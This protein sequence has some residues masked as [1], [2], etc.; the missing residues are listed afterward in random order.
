MSTADVCAAILWAGV[1]LYAIFG[2]A[3]FGAGVWDLLADLHITGRAGARPRISAERVRGQIDRS[4]GPVWE[5]NHVW[6]IFV[7][8]V[9]WTAFPTAF[10]AVMTT[11]YI[12]L[13]LAALGIVLRGSGFA[14]RHALPG[15]VQRRATTVFGISSVLTPFFMGTV[16]GAI[17]SGEVPAAGDGD[18]TGSWIGFL[19][20]VT[21]VLFVLV[22]AYTAAIFLVR[23]SGAAG[24]QDL[25]D[26]FA[27]R[28]LVAAVIAGAAAVVGVIALH[29]DA[30]Y[31]YDGLTSWPGIALVIVSGVCGLAALGLLLSGRSLGLRMAA[32]GA[33]TAVIWGY[34]AAAFPYMLPTSLKISDAAGASATLTEVIIVFAVAAV[35]VVPA[36]ILLYTLSQRQ[37]LEGYSATSDTTSPRQ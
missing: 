23:D 30:R 1:T 4:I 24:D 11:L 13:A 5:A 7:L 6:L 18:P 17:A 25:R 20:L 3:D 37:A 10:S 21:G 33:G 28:A 29:A 15:P 8:V 19:P 14:F 26:Y 16:V 32:V 22:A 12:P 31:V 35:T 27:G 36:L 34:F 2:G 9:L